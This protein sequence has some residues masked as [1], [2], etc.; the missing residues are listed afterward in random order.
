GRDAPRRLSTTR[1]RARTGRA[2]VPAF[3]FGTSDLEIGISREVAPGTRFFSSRGSNLGNPSVSGLRGSVA[4]SE[5]RLRVRRPARMGSLRRPP[6]QPPIRSVRTSG[7]SYAGV[8]IFA[9][10]LETPT[11]FRFP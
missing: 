10:R 9:P 11:L 2:R 3:P 4:G 7:K 1:P 8:V 6:G 5:T